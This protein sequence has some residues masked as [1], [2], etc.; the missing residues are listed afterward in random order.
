MFISL[1]WKSLILLSVFLVLVSC[2]WISQNI[3]QSVNYFN[4]KI[5]IKHEERSNILNE[6]VN[7]KLNSISQLSLLLSENSKIKELTAKNSTKASKAFFENKLMSLSINSGIEFMLIL[8]KYKKLTHWTSVGFQESDIQLITQEINTLNI[9]DNNAKPQNFLWC[10]Q[11]CYLFNIE[12]YFDANDEVNYIV[13]ASNIADLVIKFNGYT[14]TD[15]IFSIKETKENPSKI[16]K[17]DL[18]WA[19]SNH[20]T[21]KNIIHQ[22][23]KNDVFI[24]SK[25]ETLIL[26]E[27]HHY[28]IKQLHFNSL[29]VTGRPLNII[30]ISDETSIHSAL[31]KSV[32]SGIIIGLLGLVISEA[33]LLIIILAPLKRLVNVAKALRL[34]PKNQYEKVNAIVKVKSS[35]VKDELTSLE[36]STLSLSS[37]L[38][39]LNN[40]VLDKNNRLTE[41]IAILSR[42]RAF[43]EQLLDKSNLF[44]ITLDRELNILTENKL[45]TSLSTN[46]INN[47]KAL[48]K[49]NDNYFQNLD[50]LKAVFSENLNHLNQE[51]E[52]HF[53]D[54]SQKFISWTHTL[55]ENDYGN[56]IILTIGMDLTYR[57]ESENALNW[58]ANHDSLTKLPNR[59]Y[60]GEKLKDLINSNTN[61]ALIFIDVNKFKMIN[62]LYG[63]AAGDEVLLKIASI[64]KLQT[65]HND[66]IARLAGDEFTVILYRIQEQQLY[67][68]LDNLNKALQGNIIVGEN[69]IQ[70]SCSLGVTLFPEHGNNS[71]K[72]IVNAD[73]AMYK[74]KQNSGGA[75][76]LYDSTSDY[77]V[78][79]KLDQ[80]LSFLIKESIHNNS[81]T[82]VFQPIM[83]IQQETIEHFEVLIRLNDLEG[84]AVYPDV[85]IPAAERFGLITKID[86]WV[87]RTAFK[88]LKVIHKLYGEKIKF[89]INISAPSLQSINFPAVINEEIKESGVSPEFI[90]IELTETAYIE[91]FAQV[92]ENIT[93]LKTYGFKISLDDFGTGYSS[94]NYLIQLPLDYVKLD[95]SYIKNLMN[96]THE[97]IFV[98]NISNLAHSLGMKT[99]AEYVETQDILNMISEMGITYGQGYFIGKPDA[100]LHMKKVD[101]T[102]DP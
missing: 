30:E 88:K 55:V 68:V 25:D 26:I 89:S 5:A 73:M 54:S 36:E 94:F 76:E 2:L 80:D 14:S 45:F 40:D 98:K 87:M 71:A 39:T 12:P 97:Q 32:I 74:A 102:I 50:E 23:F 77:L 64:L 44:I 46:K 93:L 13:L 18:I 28:F 10:N 49:Q 33:L 67:K 62:D 37:E 21:T 57:I 100:K 41:Q 31:I 90:I 53:D 58:L 95:G 91:N 56:E 63:H 101:Y 42:S 3:Y 84:N 81:F 7:D 69:K 51:L 61:G 96:N 99:I 9:A 22:N 4:N 1:K 43:L 29:P 82:L 85:F 75:W 20:L 24:Y 48:L 16:T 78:K 92:L 11:A 6:L 8:S 70:F 17:S 83:N 86:Q 47:F 34:L 66:I 15:L 27:D 35:F 79:M 52:I 60:F 59:R 38:E 72:L 65:R 19:A